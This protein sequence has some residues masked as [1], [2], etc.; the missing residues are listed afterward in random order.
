MKKLKILMI[1]LFVLALTA[2]NTS[3]KDADTT[4]TDNETDQESQSEKDPEIDE[5]EKKINELES[6][7][8]EKNEVE[9]KD[10]E[11]SDKKT[12]IDSKSAS[13]EKSE[14]KTVVEKYTGASYITV[15]KPQNEASL[16]EEPVIF[17]GVVSPN[18]KKIV[19]TS[20]SGD[21]ACNPNQSLCLEYHEDNYT[22]KEFKLGDD[23][24]IYRAKRDWKNLSEGTNDFTFKA[25]F[26]DGTTKTT[27]LT[28]YYNHGGAEMGKPVIY[29]YPE[30]ETEVS[31]NVRPTSGISIS[32]PEIGDGWKVIASPNGEL[33]NI[34][35]GKTY[36]YLF[37]EGFAANFK[38]PKEGF[39]VAMKDVSR[40]FDEKLRILGL[41]EKE[42][43]DFKEFWVPRLNENK[44]YFITFIS[45]ADFDKYAPLTVDP[46]PDSVIR[47]FFDYKGLDKKIKVREQKLKK[48]ERK[49]FAVIEWGG[50]LYR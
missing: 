35:D 27:S 22:L 11:T 33:Y 30:K 48:A 20:K 46:K 15:N 2:C 26:E 41:N 18:A 14:V 32:E 29:L 1:G 34:D 10:E 44:Y 16:T 3:K 9:E 23:S 13:D 17:S 36:P 21:P 47:V 12:E 4:V 28:V 5:L 8:S 39:M 31:V 37:W 24:F 50:R 42:I 38:T 6:K 7:L 40:F 49:G 45:Q 19:V 25:Y 43:T